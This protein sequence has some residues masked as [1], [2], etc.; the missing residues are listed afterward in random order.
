MATMKYDIPLFDR[1]AKF[2]LLQIKMR[3]IFVQ[4]GLDDAF[5][6]IEK[7]LSSLKTEEKQRKDKKTLSQIHMHLSNKIL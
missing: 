2:S 7:M 6:G 4:M 1:S 3:A 5:L